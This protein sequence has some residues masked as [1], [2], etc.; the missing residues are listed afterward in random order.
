MWAVELGCFCE[1]EDRRLLETLAAQAVPVK[2]FRGHEFRED[3]RFFDEVTVPCGSCWF[4]RQAAAASSWRADWWGTPADYDCSA[5]YPRIPEALVNREYQLTTLGDFCWNA[6]RF[7][8]RSAG[9]HGGLFVRPDSGFKEF[10]GSVLQSA[11]LPQWWQ[12]R[13]ALYTPSDLP[14]LIAPAVTIGQEWRCLVLDSEIIAASSYRPTYSV[15]IPAPVREFV[16]RLLPTCGFPARAF[17]ADVGE[18]ADG[19]RVLELGCLLCCSWYEAD[20]SAV[21]A[22]LR[23]LTE[24]SSA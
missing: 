3:P 21:V 8:A 12:A 4:L 13:A 7:F 22:G 19:P 24:L 17:I 2:T 16:E 9:E 14:I 23:R 1:T 18:T 20:V 5:Y 15:G 10:T 6:D 11:D